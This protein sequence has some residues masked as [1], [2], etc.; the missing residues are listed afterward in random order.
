MGRQTIG[1]VIGALAIALT[2]WLAEP[3]ATVRSQ[4][5]VTRPPAEASGRLVLPRARDVF[6]VAAGTAS[7]QRLVSGSPLTTVTQASWSPDGRRIAY[8]LFRFWRPERP[9]G[10]DLLTVGADGGEPTAVL[11]AV[12]EDVSFTEPVWTP[13]GAALV[14]AAIIRIADSRL[15]ET[16]NQVERVPAGGGERTVLVDNALS[17]AVSRDGRRLAFLRATQTATQE[18]VSLWVA[19]ADGRDPRVVLADTRFNSLAFPRFS[20]T[21]DKIA[22]AAVGGPVGPASRQGAQHLPLVP[23]VAL[24]HGLPWDLWEIRTDGSGLRRLTDLAEDDPSIAWSPD[25][26]W[27]AFQGGSGVYLVDVGPSTLYQISDAVGFGGI[28]WTP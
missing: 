5:I 23:S 4:T 11:P 8:S 1:A 6:Q 25:G 28:D 15:G 2:L 20:P 24:A 13:D 16:R 9:A 21:E 3:L 27:L 26:R 17:P 22:F 18:D 19:D 10:S 14:Y 12:G 7:E